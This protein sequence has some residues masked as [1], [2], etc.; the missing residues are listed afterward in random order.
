M[1][2]KEGCLAVGVV[3]ALL[4]GAGACTSGGGEPAARPKATAVPACEDG[5]YA[6]FNVDRR[7]VLTGVA[8]KQKLGKEGG[9]LTREMTPLH[10]PRVAVAFERGP[11][12]DAK[13]VLRSLGTRTGDADDDPGF[14]DVHRPA[15]DPRA[16][17]TD[18]EG[19]GTFVNYSWVKQVVADFTYTC[20]DG[21]RTTGRATSWVV[22]GSGV[23]DCSLPAEDAKE[24]DPALA[25]ARFSCDPHDPAVKPGKGRPARPASS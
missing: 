14:T 20:G 23:L 15:P 24:G 3:A 13:A 10:V 19:A 9:V 16:V 1:G 4:T 25:A 21:G 2:I 11:G 6:W 7:D 18:M 5:T 8:E 22:N 17:T 12:I